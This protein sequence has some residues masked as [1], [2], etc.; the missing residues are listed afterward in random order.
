ME[1]TR[2]PNTILLV[3]DD[4]FEAVI[5]ERVFRDLSLTGLLVHVA[6]AEQALTCLLNRRDEPPCAILL[7]LNMPGMTGLELLEIIKADSKLKDIPVVVVTTSQRQEDMTMSF[8]LGAAAYVVKSS[9]YGEY[10]ES[11][12][13]IGKFLQPRVSE[14]SLEGAGTSM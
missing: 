1:E 4:S 5:T 13:S 2:G 14:D 10:R 9:D 8:A 11:I 3:D 12:K 6:G 7:D